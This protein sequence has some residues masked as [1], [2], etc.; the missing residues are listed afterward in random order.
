MIYLE[1]GQGGSPFCLVLPDTIQTP[2]SRSLLRV[3][4]LGLIGRILTK[5]MMIVQR[6]LTD[7]EYIFNQ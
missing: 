3:A 7:A 5:P 4:A 6:W 1:C 2:L